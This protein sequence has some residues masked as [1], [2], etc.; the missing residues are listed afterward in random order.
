[1]VYPDGKAL[2]YGQVVVA[3]ISLGEVCRESRELGACPI[4]TGLPVELALQ[5]LGNFAFL[6]ASGMAQTCT[7]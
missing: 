6:G 7:Q 1:M 3:K 4:C 2:T 5:N